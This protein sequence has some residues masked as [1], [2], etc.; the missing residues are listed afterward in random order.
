MMGKMSL[1]IFSPEVYANSPAELF[2]KI[3]A[4]GFEQVQFDFLSVCDE[5]MPAFISDATLAECKLQAERNGVKISV[6]NGTY[7]MC[8]PEK[9]VREDGAKRFWE[10]CRAADALGCPVVSLCTGTRTRDNMWMAHPE[11]CKPEAWTDLSASVE[12]ALE[13]AE[14]YHIVLG[15]ETEASNVCHSAE[16]VQRLI[17]DMRSDRLRVIMDCANLFGAGTAHKAMVRDVIRKGFDLLGEYVVVAHG[18][19]IQE[20]SGIDF[21]YTGNGIVDFRFFLNELEKIG[22]KNGI[23]LH[24]TK[25]ESEIPLA[26]VNMRAFEAQD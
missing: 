3:K 20:G 4:Y 10:I 6:L 13:A 21:T 2:R 7:N 22:F 16:K 9:A 5:E 25:N 19:D 23:I 24:G 12:K 14:A 15:L 11:N 1:G 8:H 26:V 17:R 18:K